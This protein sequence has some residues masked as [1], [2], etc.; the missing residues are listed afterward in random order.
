MASKSARALPSASFI[1]RVTT[2]IRESTSVQVVSPFG[3]GTLAFLVMFLSVM[4]PPPFYEAVVRED[5]L[6]FGNP[7]T[8]AYYTGCILAF[9]GGAMLIRFKPPML[10]VMRTKLGEGRP[11]L[12]LKITIPLI[13][14]SALGLLSAL[15]IIQS[16]PSL[17]GLILS[18]PRRAGEED[19]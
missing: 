13:A 12:W 10:R 9:I 3:L 16:N 8:I 7:L 15:I 14:A 4:L 1:A 19:A 2:K 17:I 11:N 5:D 18:G 6:M